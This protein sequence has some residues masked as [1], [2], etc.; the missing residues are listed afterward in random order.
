LKAD[1]HV[2]LNMYS[3]ATSAIQGKMLDKTARAVL[4]VDDFQLFRAVVR[5]VQASR[6]IASRTGFGWTP[7]ICPMRCSSSTQKPAIEK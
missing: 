1:F 5:S 3:A 6:E 7:T 4:P 2:V